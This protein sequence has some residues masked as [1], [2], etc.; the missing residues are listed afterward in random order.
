ML[1]SVVAQMPWAEGFTIDAASRSV[2]LHDGSGGKS[3]G[4][5]CSEVFA[6]TVSAA[7]D[8]DIFAIMHGE[9]S[10][11]YPILGAG[12]PDQPVHVERFSAPLFGIASRGAHLVAY[13]YSRTGTAAGVGGP[14]ADAEPARE[15][16][17][18][19]ARRSPHIFTFPDML[20]TS[21]AGGVKAA[22]TPFDCIVAE[23][24]EEASLPP[25]WTR[26]HV[27]ARGLVSYVKR[28]SKTG[29]I[30]PTV[31]YV[32]DAEVPED[33]KLEPGHDREVAA[34]YLWTVGQVR[35]A[36][37]AGQ[38]KPNCALVMIDFFV[39]HGILTPETE[40]DYIEIVTRLRMQLPV[41]VSPASRS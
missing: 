14:G 19:I 34:F 2:Q 24:E 6:K 33:V 31:L 1:P 17:I 7:V 30:A 16:R 9:H 38:F 29:Y 32:Y 28:H 13:T 27:R 10:E 8:A 22:D 23:A 18:W 41:P 4:R 40:A 11:L 21:V 35:D 12:Y 5:A 36:L 39:R 26:R 3:T 20:D 25:S 15:L 37:E